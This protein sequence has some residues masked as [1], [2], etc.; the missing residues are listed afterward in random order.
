MD[1]YR[2]WDTKSEHMI[3]AYEPEDQG[4]REYYPLAFP[5]GFSHWHKDDLV[6]MRGIGIKDVQ[7]KEIFVHDNI[8]F[9][10]IDSMTGTLKKDSPLAMYVVTDDPFMISHVALQV[11]ELSKGLLIVGNTFEGLYKEL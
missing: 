3:Y 11:K 4:K 8:V 5:L 10:Y 7:G 6:I 1:N 2:A 9:G